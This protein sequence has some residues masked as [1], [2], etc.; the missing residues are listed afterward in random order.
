MRCQLGNLYTV[1]TRL[2]P[3]WYEGSMRL[4]IWLKKEGLRR[5]HFADQINVDRATIS[6]YVTGARRPDWD[7]LQR[8]V[9][10]T[11]GAVTADD[12]LPRPPPK[13]GRQRPSS[14][15]EART[16]D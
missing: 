6:R 15:S 4:G 9:E 2:V 10:R 12:F 16:A 11:K 8:I 14:R 5:V 13:R 3:M 1:L 7:V